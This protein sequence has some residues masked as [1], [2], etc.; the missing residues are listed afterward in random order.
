MIVAYERKAYVY[1]PG[2][3]RITFD[4]NV[5]ASSQTQMFG[6]RDISYDFLREYDKVLEVKYDEFVP[7]FLLQLLETG[8]MRQSAY[9]KYQ[10]CRECAAL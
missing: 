5:R 9:S 2:N 8:S 4:R 3:V 1:E 10:L 7:G 6:Q